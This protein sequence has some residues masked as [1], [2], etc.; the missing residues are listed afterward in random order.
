MFNQNEWRPPGGMA[1]SQPQFPQE[2][3]Y[4]YTNPQDQYQ[5]QN[6]QQPAIFYYDYSRGQQRFSSNKYRSKSYLR[7]QTPT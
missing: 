4:Y 5:L 7:L 1:T 2:H 6:E 3:N